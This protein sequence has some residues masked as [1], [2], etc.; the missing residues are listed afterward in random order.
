MPARETGG[1]HMSSFV[2]PSH[3]PS[4]QSGPDW[5]VWA[6]GH[7]YISPVWL[8]WRHKPRDGPAPIPPPGAQDRHPNTVS[9]GLCF[10]WPHGWCVCV[11]SCF[12]V[13]SSVKCWG[14]G[15]PGLFREGKQ[16]SGSSQEA[17]QRWNISMVDTPPGWAQLSPDR[18]HSP[19]VTQAWGGICVW[20][21]SHSASAG[22]KDYT[23]QDSCICELL[24]A[25]PV[26]VHS[27][28]PR[29]H[30]PREL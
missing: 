4:G 14:R 26:P 28:S 21:L 23:H 25:A 10:F 27:S 30:Q 29:P 6:C 17:P 7:V 18:K 8:L 15:L 16:G 13:S 1:F 19:T 12:F 9:P 11:A 3:D 22:L 2:R 5:R 20:P 24:S